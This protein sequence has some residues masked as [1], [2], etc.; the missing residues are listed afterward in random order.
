MQVGAKVK[1]YVQFKG[2]NILFKERGDLILLK[3]AQRLEG[4]GELEHMPKLEGRRMLVFVVPKK[5]S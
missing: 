3:F 2:R 5:K 4:L 1:S